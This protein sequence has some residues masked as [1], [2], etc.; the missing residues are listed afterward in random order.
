[1]KKL[2]LPNYLDYVILTSLSEK[3]GL[4][5]YPHL[6]AELTEFLNRYI[7]YHAENGNPWNFDS[8]FIS[9]E[10]K[11][12][13][14]THYKTP[15][16]ILK[17]INDMRKF[18]SP[19]VCPM[20]G[21]FGTGTLDHFLPQEHYP[22]FSIYTRNLVPACKC[23]TLK[24]TLAIGTNTSERLLH[25][26][27]DECLNYRLITS[28]IEGNNLELPTIN[29]HSIEYDDCN[30]VTVNFHIDKIVKKTGILDILNKKWIALTR[31]PKSVIL[32]F[33]STQ[34]NNL[35]DC[36]TFIEECLDAYDDQFAT[37]NNWMSVLISGILNDDDVIQWVYERHNGIVNGTIMPN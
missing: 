33:P 29:I 14:Q 36:T 17:V 19:D 2:D 20:C 35:V 31:R 26:Y 1:M 4:V 5:S 28:S 30:S 22:W 24:G 10:L 13:L 7:E 23:N 21:S 37:P 12:A 32:T 27:Y 15:P 11:T 16:N 18:G 25:P 8:L 6:Q 3:R 34:I 9:Q